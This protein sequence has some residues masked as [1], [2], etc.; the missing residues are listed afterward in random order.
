MSVHQLSQH[1]AMGSAETPIH[2]APAVTLADGGSFIPQHYLRYSHTLA[3]V[4]E[5]ASRVRFADEVL[6]FAHEDK[7]GMYI[8]IGM[9]GRENYERGNTI[10]PL[11]LVYGRK[12]RIDADTPTSEI[13][14]T[15]FLAI[16][17]MREHEVRELL[18]L[19]DETSGKASTPFSTHHDVHVLARFAPPGTPTATTADASE[20]IVSWLDP[21]R[22][23]QRRIALLEVNQH[24]GGSWI[25]DLVLGMLPLARAMEA[26]LPEFNHL[27]LTIVLKELS[28]SELLHQ[29]MQA[30]IDHSD[31]AVE[32]AFQYQ[33]FA[34]FSR[35]L[36]PATIAGLSIAARP[37]ARDARN[38]AFSESFKA[39][40]YEVDA[41]RAPALGKGR[42]ADINRHKLAQFTNLSGH[43][44]KGLHTVAQSV[45]SVRS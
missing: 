1:T 10:R 30:M 14:Q 34:R 26:D 20:A 3:S 22:F 21:V 12:W 8:Q 18:T 41:S 9:V 27:A 13:V 38:A 28:R 45:Q 43:M 31:R 35:T 36:D 24:R 39:S 29:I 4:Q 32:A 37:Y 15:I 11:K 6:I 2:Q 33:G 25:V 42:L 17:K 23:G 5:I 7:Q 19:R 16:K 44:P 40:N